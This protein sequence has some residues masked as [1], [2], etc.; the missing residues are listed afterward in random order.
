MSTTMS[1][2]KNYVARM[3]LIDDTWK[4]WHQFVFKDC[5]YCLALFVAI[6]YRNK[7]SS[8]KLI[9]PLFETFDRTTYQQLIPNHLA[10][11]KS[12]LAKS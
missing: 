6:R 11:I 8:L 10:G 12:F 3:A 9:A 4:F 1:K 5:L 2:F 7:V